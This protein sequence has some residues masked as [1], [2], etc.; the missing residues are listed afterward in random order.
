[1]RTWGCHCLH[2]MRIVLCSCR[3]RPQV[4]SQTACGVKNTR[5]ILSGRGRGSARCGFNQMAVG[6]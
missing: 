1:M 5:H 6:P 4:A 2:L 3:S